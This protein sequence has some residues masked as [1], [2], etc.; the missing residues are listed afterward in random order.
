[1]DGS[2]FRIPILFATIIGKTDAYS[3]TKICQETKPVVLFRIAWEGLGGRIVQCREWEIHHLL[4]RFQHSASQFVHTNPAPKAYA[5][6]KKCGLSA[7]LFGPF[8][9]GAT[10]IGATCDSFSGSK[11]LWK[12]R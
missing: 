10:S 8:M 9:D 6:C 2:I 3:H 11:L 1:M 4:L 5:S 7:T 12:I